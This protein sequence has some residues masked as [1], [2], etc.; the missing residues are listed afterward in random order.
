MKI[1]LSKESR[2]IPILME[3]NMINEGEFLED[4]YLQVSDNDYA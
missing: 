2:I 1:L 3:K 4:Y